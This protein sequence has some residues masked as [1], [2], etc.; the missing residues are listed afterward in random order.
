MAEQLYLS[1]DELG[2]R[3]GLS[4]KTIQEWRQ[5]RTRRGPQFVRFGNRVRYPIE[6]VRRYE[7]EQLA[8]ATRAT[9]AAAGA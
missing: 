7:R 9:R 1:Q 4:P 3:W 5:R 8:R 6:E 2:A